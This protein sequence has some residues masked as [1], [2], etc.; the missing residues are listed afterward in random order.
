MIW[1]VEELVRSTQSPSNTRVGMTHTGTDPS[2]GSASYVWNSTQNF[3]DDPQTMVFDYL[4]SKWEHVSYKIT[5]SENNPPEGTYVYTFEFEHPSQVK[6]MTFPYVNLPEDVLDTQ[7]LLMPF[8]VFLEETHKIEY[9]WMQYD[10]DSFRRAT[11]KEIEMRLGRNL[12]QIK[13]C[14]V[15]GGNEGCDEVN[16][17]PYPKFDTSGKIK[18]KPHYNITIAEIVELELSYTS[19]SGMTFKM[20]IEDSDGNTHGFFPQHPN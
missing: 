3:E 12:A 16:F 4:D 7:T 18:Y 13:W 20:I 2:P 6:E 17:R 8:P 11:K 10:G 1:P 5:F 14:K 9:E 19:I 15:M